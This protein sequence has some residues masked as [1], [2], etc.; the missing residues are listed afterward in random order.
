MTKRRVEKERI[1]GLAAGA[2][3]LVLA[4]CADPARVVLYDERHAGDKAPAPVVASRPAQQAPASRPSAAVKHEVRSGDTVYTVAL[5]HK[6]PIRSLIELNRLRAPYLLRSGQVLRLPKPRRHVVRPGDTIYG[7]S[8]T[9]DVAVS[10]LVQLNGLTPPYKIVVGRD[11]RLPGS[12]APAEPAKSAPA[13]KQMA[14]GAL[15][16]LPKTQR[17]KSRLTQKPP[18]PPRDA[19]AASRKLQAAVPKPPPLSSRKFLLPVRGRLLSRFGPKGRGLRNDGVNIAAPRGT[20]VRAAE[21][22]I[23]VY[24]GNA[25]LGFGNMV[26]VRHANGY[27]TAYAHNESISVARGETVRR[28]QVIAT[29]G[30]TGNVASPQLHFEIRKGK[31]AVDPKKFLPNL[32]SVS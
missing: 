30:S 2:V 19:A 23:V 32:A 27:M 1:P 6:V 24:S 21:N 15:P 9:Y 11:L 12:V 29:V 8:R 7:I 3:L 31:R 4:G 14:R 20:P 18:R 25:L 16:P 10:R 22:G 28:G 17:G 13:P 5:R 26:L